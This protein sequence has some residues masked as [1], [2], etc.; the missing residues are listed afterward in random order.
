MLNCETYVLVGNEH[1]HRFN[2]I[3]ERHP[4]VEYPPYV[5]SRAQNGSREFIA[6]VNRRAPR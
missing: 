4:T 1:T 2:R 3:W 5:H 6:V